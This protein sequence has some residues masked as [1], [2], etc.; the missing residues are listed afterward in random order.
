MKNARLDMRLCGGLLMFTVQA[1]SDNVPNPDL[2]PMPKQYEAAGGWFDAADVPLWMEPDN[3][4][5]EIAV[6]EL[7]V[8]IRELGGTPGAIANAAA[9]VYVGGKAADMQEGIMRAREAM[10]SGAALA[11]LATVRELYRAG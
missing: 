8:R 5:C 6:R 9:A 4:Q 3:R 7:S 2:V 10:R 1:I 11:K